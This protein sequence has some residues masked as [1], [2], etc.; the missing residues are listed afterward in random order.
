MTDS[1]SRISTT[2][3]GE[4]MGERAW[5]MHSVLFAGLVVVTVGAILL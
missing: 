1:N 4:G 5:R 2:T 3:I